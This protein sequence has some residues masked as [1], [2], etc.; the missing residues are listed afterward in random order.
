MKIC[1]DRIDLPTTDP[2]F[3]RV[4]LYSVVLRT[5]GIR[6]SRLWLA[7]VH[8]PHKS[9]TGSQHPKADKTESVASGFHNSQ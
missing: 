6:K 2:N 1:S 9:N 5:D 7:L 3:Y 4:V 8:P